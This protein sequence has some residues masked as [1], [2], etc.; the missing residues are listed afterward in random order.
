[1]KLWDTIE[2]LTLDHGGSIAHHHGV[3]LFRNPWIRRE[4]GAGLDLL[5]TIKDALDPGNLLNPGKLG[6]RPAEGAVDIRN[7]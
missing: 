2:G 3:G 1:A 7:G 4:L 5:Q 6:L